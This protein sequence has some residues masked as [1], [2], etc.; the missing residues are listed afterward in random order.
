MKNFL[1]KNE[2]MS[3]PFLKRLQK[4]HFFRLSKV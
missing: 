2:I 4:R 3:Q 1:F